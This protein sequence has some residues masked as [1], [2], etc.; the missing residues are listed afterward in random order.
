MSYYPLFVELAGRKAVV[1]GGGTVAER[2]IET[3][4]EYGAVVHVISRDL[5]PELQDRLK[6]GDI[7]LISREFDE[8]HIIGAFIVIAAT[9]DK[10]LNQRV[11]E[12]AKGL[13]ILVNAVDQPEECSFI[14]P[15]IIKRGDL[16]IAVS[17]SGKS[18]A[19]AR[20]IRETLAAQFGKEYE[21]FLNM[22]A[23]IRKLLLSEDISEGE[24]GRIF[25]E[26]VDSSILE[27]I[28]KQDLPTVASA[29]E[30]ILRREFSNDDVIDYMKEE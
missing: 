25:Y 26:L 14:V 13:N 3:L 6:N 4:L 30:R 19:L 1:I 7:R 2:K 17:T 24:R 20:R 22:M 28:R 11:S 23:R 5:T 12:A 15:S 8:S 9:N 18:P 21:Y 29:L 16:L 27:S 10:G